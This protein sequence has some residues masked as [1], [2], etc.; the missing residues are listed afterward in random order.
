MTTKN[1]TLRSLLRALLAVFV[2]V[3]GHAH[4]AEPFQNTFEF[5]TYSFKPQDSSGDLTGPATPPNAN[6]SVASSTSVA[7]LYMR[8]VSD[9]IGVQLAVGIPPKFSI[10]G[11][12][13]V[14]PMGKVATTTA[15]NPAVA[16]LYFFGDSSDKLRPLVGAGLNYT[17]FV[18]TRS[19]NAL[20]AA[21]GP[22][23]GSLKSSWGP[24]VIAGATYRLDERWSLNGTV[25]YVKVKTTAT[26]V[27]AG[28]TRTLDVKVD[29]VVVKLT[30]GYAF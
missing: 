16:A 17:K 26:L 7:L 2:A 18:Q 5:G 19:T 22:T 4:A 20:D 14:A 11:T 23:T 28:I 29:P 15:I 10:Y 24:L 25:S 8:M 27:S 21:L 6:V 12:G 3:Y 30:V 1:Q 13:S 9:N